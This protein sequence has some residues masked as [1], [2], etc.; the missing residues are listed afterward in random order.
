VA[1]RAVVDLHPEPR[2]DGLGLQVPPELPGVLPGLGLLD[3]GVLVL[4]VVLLPLEEGELGL[5]GLGQ[6]DCGFSG[7]VALHGDQFGALALDVHQFAFDLRPV[8]VLEYLLASDFGQ[9]LADDVVL[10]VFLLELELDLLEVI[11]EPHAVIAL[12]HV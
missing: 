11:V 8:Q 10:L 9:L 2:L 12:D 1:L 6:S 4:V 5:V 7:A 3:L